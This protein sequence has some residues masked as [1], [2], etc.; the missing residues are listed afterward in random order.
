MRCGSKILVKNRSKKK[1][2]SFYVIV[3]I[4]AAFSNTLYGSDPPQIEITEPGDENYV[5]NNTCVNI[6]VNLTDDNYNS[7]FI[8]WN[9]SLVGYW[10]FEYTNNT[11][12]NDNSTYGNDATC[13]DRNGTNNITVGKYGNSLYFNG[14][15]SQYLNCG[16]SSSFDMTNNITIELWAKEFESSFNKTLG[17]SDGH[18]NDSAHSIQQ[19]SDGGYII[20][21]ETESYGAGGKDVWLVKID[22]N[23]SEQWNETFGGIENESGWSVQQTTD[24]GYI[25]TGYTIS[26][27]NDVTDKNLWLIKTDSSG[28]EDWNRS[29]GGA[30]DDEGFCVQQ[31]SSTGKY[32]VTGYTMSF[33]D[34]TGGPNK[35]L[36]ILQIDSD[37]NERLQNG[38]HSGG[39]HE[40]GH[41]IQQT[42]EGGYIITGYITRG[43]NADLWVLETN[44]TV[45]HDNITGNWTI[46][47]EQED[48]GRS[49][50]QTSD[51]NYIVTGYTDSFGLGLL[52]LWILKIDS[53]TGTVIDGLNYTYGGDENDAGYSVNQVSDGGY[54]IT[55][56]TESY[57]AG[58][59][60]IWLVK[61]DSNGIELWN[62]TFGSSKNDTGYLAQETTDGGYIIAGRSNFSDDKDL[63][64]IKTNATGIIT[65]SNNN[66]S[67]NKILLGKGRDAYQIKLRNGTIY[68]YLNN[69]IRVSANISLYNLSQ[70]WNHLALTYNGSEIRLY[71]NGTL[72]NS[73]AYAESININTNNLTMGKNFSGIID[74]VRIWNR[75]LNQDEIN[76]SYSCSGP[77]YRNFTNLPDWNYTYY[78]YSI[79]TEGNENQT[80]NRSVWVDAT[81]PTISNY[82]P[83]HGSSTTDTTPAISADFYDGGTGIDNSS[84]I[85][86]LDGENKTSSATINWSSVTHTPSLSTGIHTVRVTVS[87]NISNT[88][89]HEWSFTISS[90]TNGN[91][92]PPPSNIAPNAD[93]GGP[94]SG[95]VSIPMLFD[96]SGSSD[97][98][99]TITNYTW[100]FGDGNTGY[101]VNPSHTYITADNYTATLTVTDDGGTTDTNTTTVTIV[102]VPLLDKPPIISNIKHLPKKV[103]SDDIVTIFATVIDDYS[104]PSVNLYWNDGSDHR[105]SMTN[106]GDIYS[107]SIG[108]LP[109]GITVKY[110]INATDATNHKNKS[111]VQNF[112]VVAPPIV[113]QIENI[114]KG[115]EKEVR[116]E[117]S[118]IT[119]IKIKSGVDL[120]NVNITIE[121]LTLDE[122]S[123]KVKYDNATV[124][125][126]F[127]MEITANDTYVNESDIES[128]EINFMVEKS[129]FIEN[130]I[131]NNTIILCRYYNNTWQKLNTT[132]INESDTHFF[133]EAK[134]P[135]LST[136]AVIGS[137]VV[138]SPKKYE[139]PEI[140]W[141]I[142]IGF[143]ISAIVI[144]IFI[145]FK[146]K[147]I[148]V[149][150]VGD[151]EKE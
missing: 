132:K 95:Y 11:Q 47:G 98:D 31:N 87:D 82:S 144:L 111:V 28:N 139:E 20:V 7:S 56:Y 46:G 18:K 84:V 99:G 19:T 6:S 120:V 16:N 92:N 125:K 9:H 131:D 72:V 140:P 91:G 14:S 90:G 149:G 66:Q 83:S 71:I 133:Y 12:V 5:T 27:G 39:L 136:F 17:L 3:L 15:N 135:G 124:Y 58:K 70:H 143:I 13:I 33:G 61:T 64:I 85:I 103:T 106:I 108:P 4:L 113:K 134:S 118:S 35:N 38:T 116:I 81:A 75:V 49:V 69:E 107:A 26:Y 137:K 117:S 24:G 96:G 23:G 88:A 112:T 21:G 148:Y 79:N 55:G 29:E 150:D 147:L 52:N 37:G 60:D 102:E 25:I 115:Q 67:L 34:M 22:S 2:F 89:Y 50:Q 129:W 77:Y 97:S 109:E 122:V 104:V 100:N 127:N 78:A 57:G 86:T 41:Y 32:I 44:S 145:L 68:G 94:Y 62:K 36:W 123:E 93:A 142:I 10:N 54:I 53:S 48:K 121:N 74:E 151:L 101:G 42:N 130:N 45:D 1:I 8:N 63:W 51:G 128:V 141:T 110:W 30:N 126:Y 59:K 65:E 138:E 114:T 76:V 40:V 105:K 43:A 80:G 119:V 73:A 146:A